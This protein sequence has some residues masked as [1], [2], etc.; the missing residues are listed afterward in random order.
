MKRDE[1]AHADRVFFTSLII[2]DVLMIVM[3]EAGLINW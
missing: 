3:F 1:R 2:F